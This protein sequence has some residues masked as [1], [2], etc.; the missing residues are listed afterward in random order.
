MNKKQIDETNLL[1]QSLNLFPGILPA[2]KSALTQK[3]AR[4]SL[5]ASSL[6]V[7]LI[8]ARWSSILWWFN[9]AWWR[10]AHWVGSGPDMIVMPI[11]RRQATR[12]LP[13]IRLGAMFGVFDKAVEH[14]R[15]G[16]VLA[17]TVWCR[18]MDNMPGRDKTWGGRRTISDRGRRFGRLRCQ[19][20]IQWDTW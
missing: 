14:L 19:L 8:V 6:H 16:E 3:P 7:P 13:H 18:G 2:C 20:L 4:F 17:E 15:S 12:I 5:F 1:F 10:S 9:T 11:A